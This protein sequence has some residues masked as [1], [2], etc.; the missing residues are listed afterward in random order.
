[1]SK[2]SQKHSRT[3]SEKSRNTCSFDRPTTQASKTRGEGTTLSYL[4]P[5][6]RIFTSEKPLDF[7]GSKANHQHDWPNVYH[8]LTTTRGW[9]PLLLSCLL[10]L[11]A[12]QISM[13]F[14]F[15]M[16][17]FRLIF[18]TYQTCHK[19]FFGF[20]GHLLHA[21]CTCSVNPLCQPCQPYKVSCFCCLNQLISSMFLVLF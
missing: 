7:S 10:E 16:A 20:L 14:Y 13:C 4:G 3:K 19:Y 8:A 5:Q 9:S 17:L 21:Y 15:F 18:V 2:Q 12:N 6:N 1:M 11:M